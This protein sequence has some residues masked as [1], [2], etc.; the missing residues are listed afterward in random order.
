MKNRILQNGLLAILLALFSVACEQRGQ[1]G[2]Q[3]SSGEI[4]DQE[5]WNSKV[6]VTERGRPSAHIRYGHMQKFT[7]K[8]L[9]I[10]DGGIVVDFF[11]PQGEHTS[12]LVAKRGRMYETSGKVEAIEQVKVVSDSGLTLYTEHLVWDPNQEKIFSDQF[13]TITTASG[14]TLF[15]E[16]FESDQNLHNWKITHPKG[17]SKKR[18]DIA[19]LEGADRSAPAADSAAAVD[20]SRQI[21]ERKFP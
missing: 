21:P 19:E 1:S 10:F 15:G 12:N 7:K 16:G 5:G 2:L 6:V 20:S 8:H 9:M 3:P 17:F 11:N 18:I 13:V 4:P 14:D